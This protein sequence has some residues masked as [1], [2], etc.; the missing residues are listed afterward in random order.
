[1][2]LRSLCADWLIEPRS[3]ARRNER[4]TAPH[5]NIPPIQ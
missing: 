5:L 3:Q 1:M 2:A 4:L